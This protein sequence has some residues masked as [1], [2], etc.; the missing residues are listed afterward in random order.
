MRL[1]TANRSPCVPVLHWAHVGDGSV[2]VS[3]V[4]LDLSGQLGRGGQA[5]GVLDGFEFYIR[6]AGAAGGIRG[7]GMPAIYTH[8]R[9]TTVRIG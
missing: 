7:L 6:L 5:L 2:N 4:V 8:P 1:G 9:C 3:H